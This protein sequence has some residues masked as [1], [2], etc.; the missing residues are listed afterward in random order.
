MLIV[1]NKP[2]HR[3]GFATALVLTDMD[4]RGMSATLF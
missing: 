2:S 3:F 1:A 4:V